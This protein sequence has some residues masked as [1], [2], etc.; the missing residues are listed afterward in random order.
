MTIFSYI[1][2]RD[3]AYISSS[4]TPELEHSEPSFAQSEPAR[5]LGQARP[6]QALAHATL[7]RKLALPRMLSPPA[8]TCSALTTLSNPRLPFAKSAT[9]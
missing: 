9:G 3:R 2:M 7:S 4:H 6:E 5:A 8:L 1:L